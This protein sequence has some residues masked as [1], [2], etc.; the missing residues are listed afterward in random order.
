ISYAPKDSQITVEVREAVDWLE[1]RVTDQGPGVPEQFQ[2]T[3][4]E[5]F[6]Q[7]DPDGTRKDSGAGL[8][9]AIC[10]KIIE[11]HNGQIGIESIEGKGSTFWFRIPYEPVA[12]SA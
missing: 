11:A 8:G 9:L 4:F 1:V 2:Q 10:K 5:R 7:V 6:K 3:I 12:A